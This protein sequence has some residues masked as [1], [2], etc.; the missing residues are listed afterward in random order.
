VCIPLCSVKS[1]QRQLLSCL[2]C[3]IFCLPQISTHAANVI[4]DYF[5]YCIRLP[6]LR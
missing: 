6:C 5:R 2:N 3:S 4:S 1:K